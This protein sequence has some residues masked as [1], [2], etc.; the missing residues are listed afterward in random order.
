MKVKGKKF[1]LWGLMLLLMLLV[2]GF[3]S[4][5]TTKEVQAAKTG[6]VT[7]NGK[8]YYRLSNGQNKKGWLT[9]GG[10]KYYFDLT[11]G[12]R[13]SGFTKIGNKTYYFTAKS[14]IMATGWV[15][16]AKGQK[17]YFGTDG[18]MRTGWQTF[19]GKKRYFSTVTGIMAT[20]WVANAKGQK[21]Y[22]GT[23]GFMRTGW[24]TDTKGQKRYFT[25][26]AG[27]MAT[28]WVKNGNGQYRY[29][30]K[31]TGVMSTGWVANGNK[32]MRYFST[33]SGVMATGWVK[34]GNGQYR[35]FDK[36]SGV[37]TTGWVSDSNGKRY[38]STSSGVMATGW[39]SD[40]KGKRYFDPKTGYMATGSE[41]IDGKSYIFD[42][43]GYVTSEE[44]LNLTVPTNERTIKN[45]LAGAIQPVGQALYIW[46][47]G[48]N[49]SNRKG[50]S[51]KW[52]EFYYSQDEDYDYQ[53]DGLNDLSAT[54]R[55]KGLDCS[56]FV[57]WAAYQA[58]H[59][60]SGEGYGYTVVANDVG[61]YYKSKGWGSVLTQ[62]QLQS[63]NYK[64]KPGDV[65]YNSG[66]TWIVLGQCTDKSIVIIHS[67]PDAGCQLS[68]TPTPDGDYSS[69]AIALAKKYMSKY[70]GYNKYDYHPSSG[71]YIRNG[72]YFRWNQS[73]LSDPDG[74]LNKTADQI[75]ADLYK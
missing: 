27:I 46:G 37:M 71:N 29:F 68:G 2:A 32:Q 55:A 63:A 51:P 1:R 72:Q 24:A 61:A 21:R 12:V 3:T 38:F 23:D 7:V 54:N 42:S 40:S 20:G 28:G 64:L 6:F 44:N 17:R 34:N 35:Y 60:T 65:G 10:K 56:G 73:I 53:A 25:A 33:G 57:G 48:W 19:N 4:Q 59:K 16:N 43:S 31:S 18:V 30:N 52:K 36:S 39:V 62:Y 49:D 69:Q 67:T 66:H 9:L 70:S 22:F 13:K 5:A 26:S 58:L 11:T 50:V 47:G 8:V 75:L 15:A 41:V 45:Y 14:G 74:Y